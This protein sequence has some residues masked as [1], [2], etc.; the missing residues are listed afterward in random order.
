MSEQS[1]ISVV[2][3]L[4]ASLSNG[5]TAH[6][7]TLLDG[8]V[9]LQVSGSH[10]QYA[11][12]H[13]GGQ[14]VAAYLSSIQGLAADITISPETVAASGDQ[15]LALIRVQGSRSGRALD[16]REVQVVTLADGKI[17]QITNYAGDQQAK[18]DFFA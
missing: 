2:Q 9:S 8:G 12:E 14:D 13:T 10:H 18:N 15:V 3:D 11:H 4:Y 17:T 6:V 5:D 7:Q 16:V 1:N